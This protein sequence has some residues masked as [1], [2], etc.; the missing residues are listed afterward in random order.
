MK[1]STGGGKVTESKLMKQ[2]KML[3]VL[4]L[5]NISTMKSLL[6]EFHRKYPPRRGIP[7]FGLTGGSCGKKGCAECPHNI[8]W[9]EYIYPQTHMETTL[10]GMKKPGYKF[11]WKD[12]RLKALPRRFWN[13]ARSED[14]LQAFR[15]FDDRM[16]LLNRNRKKLADARR[17]IKAR[18]NSLEADPL[19][20]GKAI[21]TKFQTDEMQD[22]YCP[23]I[24]NSI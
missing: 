9:R 11:R 23:I 12:Q 3:E 13:S 6:T 7:G 18:L 2:I 21:V 24:K 14:V 1:D 16:Q 19:L 22:R 10:T 4:Y 15:Y 5:D 8:Y 17:T 20:R